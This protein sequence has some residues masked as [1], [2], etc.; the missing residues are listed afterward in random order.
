[1]VRLKPCPFK[2]LNTMNLTG[3]SPDLNRLV[4]ARLNRLLKNSGVP[5]L[6]QCTT[7]LVPKSRLFFSSV[8]RL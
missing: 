6:C 8:S 5:A 7:L 2:A 1:M 3:Q 4:T